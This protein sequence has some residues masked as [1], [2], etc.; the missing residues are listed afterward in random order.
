MAARSFTSETDKRV[1]SSPEKA[2]LRGAQR[3]SEG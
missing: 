3:S 2:A 1:K